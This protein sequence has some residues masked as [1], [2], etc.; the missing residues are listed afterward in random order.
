[1]RTVL[2]VEE[3]VV[4]EVVW[5]VFSAIGSE[6]ILG[7]DII[8]SGFKLDVDVVSELE[9]VNVG[10]DIIGSGDLDVELIGTKIGSVTDDTVT[11]DSVVVCGANS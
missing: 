9:D 11:V 5:V 10:A 2:E 3:D 7:A 6:I 1:M 8:D 4:V